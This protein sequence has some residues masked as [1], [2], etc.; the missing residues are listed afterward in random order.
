MR[1]YLERSTHFGGALHFW[2]H[3]SQSGIKRELGVEKCPTSTHGTGIDLDPLRATSIP[4]PSVSM[5]VFDFFVCFDSWE[6]LVSGQLSLK[7]TC[8]AA[9]PLNREAA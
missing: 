9:S 8:W 3:D 6:L 7:A 2:E 4:R 1:N 5:S